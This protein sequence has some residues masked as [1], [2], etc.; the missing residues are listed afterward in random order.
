VEVGWRLAHDV[1]G[2]GYA[3]EAAVACLE[4]GFAHAG[5]DEIVSFTSV[6]NERSRSVMHK[7]GMPRD[8]AGDFDHPRM[9]RTDPLRP[10]VLYRLRR[11]HL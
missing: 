10:H 5:L 4:L 9:A 3:T 8:P 2:R 7:I 1:W 11:S 6:L